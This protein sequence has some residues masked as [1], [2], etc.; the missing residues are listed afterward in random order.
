MSAQAT[1]LPGVRPAPPRRRKKS[2]APPV[3]PPPPE[4]VAGAPGSF[5]PARPAP[6][7]ATTVTPAGPRAPLILGTAPPVPW[8]GTGPLPGFWPWQIW[9]R[10]G[11]LA[12]AGLLT[13]AYALYW[14]GHAERTTFP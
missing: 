12:L 10:R 2:A 1:E 4:P 11:L 6:P 8:T 5:I 3:P 13:A 14:L 7:G 9:V